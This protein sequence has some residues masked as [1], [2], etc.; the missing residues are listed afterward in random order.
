MVA[1]SLLCDDTLYKQIWQLLQLPGLQ[2]PSTPKSQ[3]MSVSYL[4]NSLCLQP[5]HPAANGHAAAED[6]AEEASEAS[7]SDEVRF[8]CLLP[9]VGEPD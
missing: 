7:E 9:S 2:K 1:A 4:A 5:K 3:T 8:Q 6:L